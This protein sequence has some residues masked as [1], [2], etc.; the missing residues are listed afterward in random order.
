LLPFQENFVQIALAVRG[1]IPVYVSPD[2]NSFLRFTLD[3]AESPTLLIAKDGGTHRKVFK[4]SLE[5]ETDASRR[6]LLTW[7]SENKHSLVPALDSHN[8]EEIFGMDKLIVMAIINPTDKAA[9]ENIA[10]IRLIAK[11]YNR[12]YDVHHQEKAQAAFVWL[13][14][15]EKSDYIKRVY[16]L[17]SED[18]PRII[19][20]EPR[21]DRYYDVDKSGKIFSMNQDAILANI[22]HAVAGDLKVSL[23]QFRQFKVAF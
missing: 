1:Q 2:T 11:E 8:S 22:E 15:Y 9:Q 23:H 21:E 10:L 16:G 12:Y 18:L 13:D 3:P 4:H 17:T 6:N 20:A 19:L 14:G 7:I 5:L